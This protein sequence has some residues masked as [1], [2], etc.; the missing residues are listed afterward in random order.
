MK[1]RNAPSA[2]G[3]TLVELSIVI[4]I[5]GLIISG[6]TAGA[7]LVKGA[8][9]RHIVTDVNTYTS[10]LNAFRLQ[11]NALPGD[12]AN[13]SSYWGGATNGDGNRIIDPANNEDMYAW[14]HLVLAG[15]IPGNYTGVTAGNPSRLA[16]T[17]I[18]RA[19]YKNGVGFNFWYQTGI[20]GRTQHSIVIYD[21]V[22]AVGVADTVKPVDAMAIDTKMDDGVPNKGV[23]Y[24]IRDN[25]QQPICVDQDRS[26]AATVTV[27]YIPT[28]NTFSCGMFF[29]T[30]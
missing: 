23:V 20:Y 15:L 18:P 5:I 2:R 1:Y 14:K 17:N 6:V 22:R 12:I 30:F 19:S 3:F 21:P 4:V 24:S 13:A 25:T 27:N 8:Q 10:A 16:G 29:Y 9:L 26:V 11:Y 28:D 7:S